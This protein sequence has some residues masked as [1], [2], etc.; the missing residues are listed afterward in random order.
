MIKH[1]IRTLVGLG[2]LLTCLS[3]DDKEAA[4]P[5]LSAEQTKNVV[6]GKWKIQKVD[7]RICRQGNCNTSGY[8]GNT[9]DY[10]EFRTD[11]AFLYRNTTGA[12][13]QPEKFKAAYTK[14]GAFVLTHLFWSATYNIKES[15]PDKLVLECSF[16]GADP[17]AIFTDTYYLYR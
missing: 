13:G 15:K 1:S 17:Y 5:T 8:T 6:L 9:E 7:Y 11:S 12:V 3:C 14:P 16:A 4:M 10:F 2:L